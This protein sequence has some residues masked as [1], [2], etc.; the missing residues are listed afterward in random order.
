[1][2]RG[3][4]EAVYKRRVDDRTASFDDVDV[5]RARI[6]DLEAELAR[7]RARVGFFDEILANVPIYV[8]RANAD[9][10]ITFVSRTQAP[11]RNEDVVGGDL[12]DF[13]APPARAAAVRPPGSLWWCPRRWR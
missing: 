7:A 5:L 4:P 1:M 3:P 2:A 12:Y 8:V 13:V 10:R 9:H 11:M 6:R